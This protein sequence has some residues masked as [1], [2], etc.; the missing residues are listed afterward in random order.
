MTHVNLA[1]APSRAI[2]AQV[3]FGALPCYWAKCH[4]IVRAGMLLSGRRCY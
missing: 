2:K 4:V 3:L 1:I